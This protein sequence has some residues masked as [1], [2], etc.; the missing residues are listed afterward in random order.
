MILD[1][2]VF[3]TLISD[4]TCNPCN[5]TMI[6]SSTAE[7]TTP[8]QLYRPA[9]AE[10]PWLGLEV[11]PGKLVYGENSYAGHNENLTAHSGANVW[12]NSV[13]TNVCSCEAPNYLTPPDGSAGTVQ[14]C[15][16][17]TLPGC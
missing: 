15:L 14:D 13:C 16:D 9:S 12:V 6:A 8:T 10:D 3:E 2:A 11:N 17:D 4:G 1:R 7:G 5:I